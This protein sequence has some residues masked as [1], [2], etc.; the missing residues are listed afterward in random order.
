M[1]MV[2][3]ADVFEGKQ[4]TTL[5]PSQALKVFFEAHLP[6]YQKAVQNKGAHFFRSY[7]NLSQQLDS[8]TGHLIDEQGSY[9][10]A[11]KKNF[12][13]AL[14]D[15]VLSLLVLFS[16]YKN[17]VTFE[18]V[19]DQ[20]IETFVQIPGGIELLYDACQ[21]VPF[22]DSIK[23]C[24]SLFKSGRN[25]LLEVYKVRDLLLLRLKDAH[26]FKTAFPTITFE[27][28]GEQRLECERLLRALPGKRV[29]YKAQWKGQPV[30]V[31]LFFH[32]K[33]GRKHFQREQQHL[34]QLQEKNILSPRVLFAGPAKCVQFPG[35]TAS[36]NITTADILILEYIEGQTLKAIWQSLTNSK[37]RRLLLEKCLLSLA[38]FHEK[39]CFQ[40][41]LHLDNFIES[42]GKVFVLDADLMKFYSESLNHQLS[43]EQL[44]LLF[45]QIEPEQDALAIEASKVYL[46]NRRTSR[47]LS[48]DKII[49]SREAKREKVKEKLLKK[50]FRDCT[51][52]ITLNSFLRRYVVKREQKG[53]VLQNFLSAPDTAFAKEK[54]H[55]L[56]SGN[57]CSLVRMNDEGIQY[58]VKRYNLKNFLHMLKRAL[59]R[60][61]ASN[62]WEGAHL[63]KYYGVKTPKPIAYME[64]R[65]GFIK[66]TSYFVMEH[67]ES[68]LLIRVLTDESVDVERKEKIIEE[69]ESVWTVLYRY[70]ISH[71]DLKHNN[72]LVQGSQVF[73]I[74]LDSLKQHSG[75]RSYRLAYFRD[76]ER[77]LKNFD[78]YP[79]I[80]QH[81]K[82]FFVVLEKH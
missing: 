48:I 1:T 9:L 29:T 64:K 47:G 80:A 35:Q 66:Q 67:L 25:K 59:K 26:P 7:I 20:L 54:Q 14:R 13:K 75:R 28:Q 8:S 74:D 40:A 69:I 50:I 58:V 22:N 78:D 30:V 23:Q 5:N 34:E 6:R 65:L 45:A 56:K 52:C 76:K 12:E 38:E 18:H 31:K 19:L 79:T 44:G 24:V 21:K 37:Q 33:R 41:D 17:S 2:T 11:K 32:A 73:L 72:W 16:A 63:L 43:L 55:W 53:A 68:E 81:F 61:R 10:P 4:H 42:N 27:C 49:K 51:D 60:T 36:E 82:A 77:F 62:S 39:G 46:E 15:E 3:L 57:T 70:Q 71:G